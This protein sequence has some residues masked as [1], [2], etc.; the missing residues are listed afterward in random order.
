MY[1][2]ECETT[3]R[4]IVDKDTILI[5]HPSVM[6]ARMAWHGKCKT[7]QAQGRPVDSGENK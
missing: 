3:A 7:R 5:N 4:P 1:I 2:V 6:T